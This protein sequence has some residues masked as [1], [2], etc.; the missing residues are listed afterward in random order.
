VPRILDAN[1]RHGH[2]RA[3]TKPLSLARSH[4]G[5]DQD[6]LADKIDLHRKGDELGLAIEVGDVSQCGLAEQVANL[7]RNRVGHMPFHGPYLMAPARA[8]PVFDI[9]AHIA[10]RSRTNAL[11]ASS[12]R[13]PTSSLER[14]PNQE[15]IAASRGAK[16]I[17]AK[18]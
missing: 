11:S 4:R 15:N 13:C 7:L 9:A 1:Y 6:V 16:A 14:L 3:R 17:V 12:K 2:L 8:L 10:S 5:A 18:I